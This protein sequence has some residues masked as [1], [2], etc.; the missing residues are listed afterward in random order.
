MNKG[1]RVVG[2]LVALILLS[3]GNALAMEPV[4]VILGK[5]LYFDEYLSL[6][7]NQAC[8]S[9]HLP[10]GFVDPR[11]V[12]DPWNNVVSL[13]SDET[14]NGGRNAPP[15][16][17]AAFSPIFYFDEVEGLYI[18]GQFW[19]GRAPT[20]ADQAKG[21]FLN[22]V[23]MAMPSKAAVL[24]A[25][26][27]R[28]NPNSFQY[29]LLFRIV[30]RVNLG[31]V[32]NW[33]AA[34]VDQVYDQMADAIQAFEQ[35]IFFNRFNSKF[36]QVMAGRASFTP[37][38]QRGFDLFNGKAQ[39]FLCHPSEATVVGRK[40]VPALF[41]D[42][43]YDNL[44][45]P[46]SENFLIIDNPVD[47]GLGA[48][49]G[50]PAEN[51]KFKVSTLRNIALTPPYGHNGY[52]ATLEEIVHF[53]NTRDVPGAGWDPPEVA[54][55]VNQDELGDL[56]LTAQEESDLVAFLETLSDGHGLP[57]VINPPLPY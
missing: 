1:K 47:L 36:D 29:R 31:G 26:V 56:G 51:G 13:G 22:L 2:L 45:I 3:A 15:S 28:G 16:S 27:D 9:C 25:L 38:E 52:F 20:L 6:N 8:A 7:H 32:Y 57:V 39:C 4:K 21:P 48:I 40:T 55:T 11:N 23:E 41:T 14:L 33:D 44:G 10:P 54:D 17:Y 42:F 50:D 37:E 35:S 43:T 5:L 12:A 53:Y 24:E 18:G 49:V 19:D 34:K 30:Y 46:K